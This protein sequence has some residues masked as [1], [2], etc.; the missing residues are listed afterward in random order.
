MTVIISGTDY[1]LYSNL[2]VSNMNLN[3]ILHD[4][5]SHTESNNRYFTSDLVNKMYVKTANSAYSM[6]KMVSVTQYVL[7]IM[8]KR[9]NIYEL[10]YKHTHF[11]AIPVR[12]QGEPAHTLF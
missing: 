2:N 1:V 11:F 12:F 5:Y 6:T 7:L 8:L 10:D 3:I 4:H 9:F